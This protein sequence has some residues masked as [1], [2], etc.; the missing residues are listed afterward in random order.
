MQE[1]FYEESAEII[2]KT[3]GKVKYILCN[4]MSI[5]SFILLAVWILFVV[6]GYE[7]SN[8]LIDIILLLIP[9]VLFIVFGIFMAKLKNKFYVDFDYTFVSGSVR[10]SKV[11]MNK[12][13][14]SIVQ[15][16]TTDIEKLGYYGSNLYSKYE[17]SPS[18]IKEVL[19]LNTQPNYD[20]D[21]YYIVVN[22]EGQ[23]YLYILE[24]TK[25]FIVNILKYSSKTI[26]D[27]EF[28]KA[29]TQARKNKGE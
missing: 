16:E 18:I 19:T 21:F 26:M 3:S 10:F 11:I 13:R 9:T 25:T 4:I 15:F 12:D 6:I 7:F 29:I 17:N 23:K 28:I 20:K 14:E 1:I 22:L 24:C 2:N 27:E 8:V 5:I